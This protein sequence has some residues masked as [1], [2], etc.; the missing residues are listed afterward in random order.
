MKHYEKLE[1]LYSVK[2]IQTTDVPM[3]FEQPLLDT[4]MEAMET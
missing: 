1:K 2:K 3:S 4:T